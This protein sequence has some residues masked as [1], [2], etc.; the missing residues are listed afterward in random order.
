MTLV[1]I[2]KQIQR[3]RKEFDLTQVQLADL[4]GIS[5][6]PI[7]LIEDGKSIRLDSLLKICDTLGL[8]ID[9]VSKGTMTGD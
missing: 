9:L 7:Y 8:A 3:T 5:Y 1:E 6:R 2:G 4:S